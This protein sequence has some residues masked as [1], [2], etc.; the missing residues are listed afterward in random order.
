M[1]ARKD[2]LE[3]RGFTPEQMTAINEK[4]T[5][6]GDFISKPAAKEARSIDDGEDPD[7]ETGDDMT[8]Y[9]YSA[10][11]DSDSEVLYGMFIERV[12][13]GAFKRVLG[14]KPDVRLL[15]NHIGAPHARTINGTLELEETP[16][17][18]YRKA[19]LNPNRSD[20]RNLYEAVK[21]GDY[22]QSSFAFTVK[23]D[24]WIT[25]D[26]A[27][28][29]GDDY[30]GCACIWQR[31]ILEVGELLDDSIVTYPAYPEST[32]VVTDQRE[33]TGV[34]TPSSEIVGE[35]DRQAIDAE[36]SAEA[37]AS[38]ASTSPGSDKATSIRTWIFIN[39]I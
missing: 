19:V 3:R 30:W 7:I 5:W 35:R 29:Q 16:R 2:L 28:E 12:K 32:A 1:L 33:S 36:Q 17:G 15:E 20:S 23:R 14:E 24:E 38:E 8:L 37:L 18:L 31:N 11:F 27:E 10:V 9:G 26:C 4:R 6:Q 39:S 21:R 22:S 25:C 13:R 34:V